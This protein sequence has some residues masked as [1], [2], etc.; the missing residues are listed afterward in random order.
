MAACLLGGLQH[1]HTSG[2]V[3]SM[4]KS[5]RGALRPGGILLLELSHP[6]LLFDGSIATSVDTW[7]INVEHAQV[8]PAV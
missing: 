2:D 1:M 7:T 5:V 6:A 8:G 3:L 4:L